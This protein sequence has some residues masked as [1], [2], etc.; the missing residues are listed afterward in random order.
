MKNI[1]QGNPTMVKP[2]TKTIDMEKMEEIT[3]KIQ[4]ASKIWN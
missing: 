2:S 4:N 3:Y 1:H